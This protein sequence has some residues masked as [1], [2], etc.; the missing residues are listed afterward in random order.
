MKSWR[1]YPKGDPDVDRVLIEEWLHEDL[2]LAG[3][4]G[5]VSLEYAPY[6]DAKEAWGRGKALLGAFFGESQSWGVHSYHAEIHGAKWPIEMFILCNEKGC[7]SSITYSIA[8]SRTF[9]HEIRFVK[10]RYVLNG[11]FDGEGAKEFNK[12]KDLVKRMRRTISAEHYVPERGAFGIATTAVG[13]QM[14]LDPASWQVTPNGS[15]S[16]ITAHTTVF[17][18]VDF[19]LLTMG[20]IPIYKGGWGLGVAQV[21]EGIALLETLS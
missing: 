7:I 9:P 1:K 8:S 14:Y 12:N 2:S 10:E 17:P 6:A 19:S 21:L 18:P 13:R 4:S 16:H 5:P 3:L 11:K 20:L 15:G